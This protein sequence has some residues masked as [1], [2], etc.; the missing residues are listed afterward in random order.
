MSDLKKSTIEEILILNEEIK[1][2]FLEYDFEFNLLFKTDM[3]EFYHIFNRERFQLKA[4]YLLEEQKLTKDF[5]IKFKELLEKH[6]DRLEVSLNLI[7]LVNTRM[8]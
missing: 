7:F 2:F 8:F 4:E 5:Q 6:I 1:T 3:E